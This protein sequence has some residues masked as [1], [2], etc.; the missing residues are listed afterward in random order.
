[1]AYLLA[2]PLTWW[3]EVGQGARPLSRRAAL[4]PYRSAL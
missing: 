4:R 1:M 3:A 2:K